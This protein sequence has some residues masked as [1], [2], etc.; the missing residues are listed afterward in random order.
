[1]S[2][3]DEIESLLGAYALDAVEPAEA[4]VVERH[5]QVCPRCRTEVAEHREVAGLLG[6]AGQEAP[7]GLWDR[8]AT[9]MAEAPPEVVLGPIG[10]AE[11]IRLDGGRFAGGRAAASRRRARLRGRV[12]VALATAAAVAVAVLGV[13]VARLGHREQG[14]ANAVASSGADGPSMQVVE[15][16]LHTPGARQVALAPM[17]SGSSLRAVVLP[18]GQGYLYDARLTPL[19][20]SQTYQLWGLTGSTAVSY[21]LIGSSAPSVVAFRAGAGVD[22][23]AVTAEVAGGVTHTIHAPVAAGAVTPPL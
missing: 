17:A 22:A 6:Y 13:Q 1:M 10:S 15:A 19:P 3:H 11:V 4:E 21:G 18:G 5:L 23:L 20:S 9:S 8:I 2:T 14:L 12:M 16:A 7:A